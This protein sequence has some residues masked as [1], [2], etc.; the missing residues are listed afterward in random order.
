MTQTPRSQ[1]TRLATQPAGQVDSPWAAQIL[2]ARRRAGLTQ[3]Q[4]AEQAGVGVG[5]VKNIEAG[6][7]KPQRAKLDAIKGVLGL[8]RVREQSWTDEEWQIAEVV[9]ALYSRMPEEAR[10]MAA[11]KVTALFAEMLTGMTLDASGVPR[12][13][14]HAGTTGNA[15]EYSRPTHAPSPARARGARGTTPH[16]KA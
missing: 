16:R 6:K 15:V 14:T 13:E 1:E 8:N 12:V 3:E 5:T 9:V 7:V 2:D 11:G 10:A 4:L